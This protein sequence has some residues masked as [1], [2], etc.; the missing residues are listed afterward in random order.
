MI[1]ATIIIDSIP[2]ANIT[3]LVVVTTECNLAT[4]T[5]TAPGDDGGSG[6]ATSYEIRYSTTG[7]INDTNWATATI[8]TQS[9]IPLPAG[10]TETYDVTGLTA[11]TQY[12]FAIKVGDEVPNWSGVSNSP[13]GT[14]LADNLA[15]L[16]SNIKVNGQSTIAVISGTYVT[17]TATISDSA[18]GNSDIGGANYTR[19]PQ[20]WGTST[21]MNPSDGSFDSPTEVVNITIDT[22]SLSPGTYRF[23][24][25]G[26]DVIPNKNTVSTAYATIIID[27]T[28]PTS[29]VDT[30][31]PYWQSSSY[32]ITATASDGES[33]VESVELF[34]LF[35]SDNTSW[36]LPT[37]FGVDTESPW[38]WTFDF[39]SGDGYYRFYTIAVDAAGNTESAPAT[40]DARCAYDTELP[41]STADTISPYWC[42]TSPL[43]ITATADDVGSGLVAVELFYR[44]STDNS[45][46]SSWISF[47]VK[48][49]TPWEWSFD[50]P[51]GDGYYEFYTVAYDFAQNEE[52][53]TVAEVICGYDITSPTANAGLDQE[54]I[55]GSIVT[56][57]GS[58]SSDTILLF[59]LTWTFVDGTIKTLYGVNPTYIFSTMGSYQVTLEVTDAAGNSNTD[60]MWVNVSEAITTGSISGIVTDEEGNPIKDAKVT[61]EGTSFQTTTNV[62]GHYIITDVPA[63]IYDL[64]VTKSGYETETIPDVT[65]SAGQDT[66]NEAFAM[67]KSPKEEAVGYWWIILI[68]VVVVV[69][70]LLIFLFKPK[71]KG[72]E[73]FEELEALEGEGLEPTPPESTDTTEPPKSPLSEPELSPPQEKTPPLPLP[74]E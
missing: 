72:P 25:Y 30:I 60:T 67:K 43:T 64:K 31:S 14:T 2:P 3:D 54:V 5:W 52:G 49:Q 38:E 13:T 51:N 4:L 6:T 39:P 47:E 70:I 23:Y 56:F 71:K 7:P 24:V 9:W 74:E 26:W 27:E 45:T 53:V 42:P 37:S 48:T 10:N 1:Y 61:V 57:D 29:S 46:W 28:P 33:W 15:P 19:G 22:S 34:Y 35:S 55:E 65:V 58:G 11:S 36:G 16:I 17:L 44:H 63:G 41:T 59:N 50:F 32:T 68:I 73:S 8:F 40:W 66:Q 18:T 21:N 12:W 20:D 69:V 62:T